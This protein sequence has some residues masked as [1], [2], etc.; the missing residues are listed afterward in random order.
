M[1]FLKFVI[2]TEIRINLATK[3]QNKLKEDLIQECSDKEKAYGVK[4]YR[5]VSTHDNRLAFSFY[6]DKKRYLTPFYSTNRK[7]DRAVLSYEI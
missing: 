6:L 2:V 7:C 4:E 3:F 5:P 1:L